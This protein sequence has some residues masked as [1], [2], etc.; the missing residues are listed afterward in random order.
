M[1]TLSVKDKLRAFY[2]RFS[3]IIEALGGKPPRSYRGPK[4]VR[5]CCSELRRI[6]QSESAGHWP[7]SWRCRQGRQPSQDFDTNPEGKENFPVQLKLY[8]GPLLPHG[9]YFF[10]PPVGYH[11]Y[12]C[13]IC[14]AQLPPWRWGKIDM[15][16][17]HHFE[18]FPEDGP[19]N[20]LVRGPMYRTTGFVLEPD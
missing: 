7:S 3:M 13:C 6:Y 17:D 11:P 19:E 9:G 16:V 1:K 18:R 10:N 2:V 20:N 8:A 5:R 15:C 4:T 14:D 12:K